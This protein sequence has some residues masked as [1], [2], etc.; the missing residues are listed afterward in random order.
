MKSDEKKENDDTYDDVDVDNVDLHTMTNNELALPKLEHPSGDASNNAGPSEV[1]GIDKKHKVIAMKSSQ[2]IVVKK[3]NSDPLHSIDE[4]EWDVDSWRLP[5]EYRMHENK[6]MCRYLS[7]YAKWAQKQS[8][9]GLNGLNNSTMESYIDKY[10]KQRKIILSNLNVGSSVDPSFSALANKTKH[11]LIEEIKKIS[12]F[13]KIP[14]FKGKSIAS[15]NGQQW[16]EIV[17]RKLGILRDRTRASDS[18]L[19]EAL[20]EK[21]SRPVFD[22]VEREM[23]EASARGVAYTLS[24]F[25][26]HIKTTYKCP[27]Y[28]YLAWSKFMHLPATMRKDMYDDVGIVKAINNFDST[29]A[30]LSHKWKVVVQDEVVKNMFLYCGTESF[31]RYL[32]TQRLEPSKLSLSQLKEAARGCNN[33]AKGKYVG[34]DEN[35][36]DYNPKLTANKQAERNDKKRNNTTNTTRTTKVQVNNLK[37]VNDQ[38]TGDKKHTQE[39]YVCFHCG[40]DSHH[41]SK[42]TLPIEKQQAKLAPDWYL[43]KYS[44]KVE[45]YRKRAASH[46][47]DTSEPNDSK[48]NPDKQLNEKHST[49]VYSTTSDDLEE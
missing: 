14:I 37:P 18:A 16:I 28:E 4:K 34:N 3:D 1:D 46:V 20:F 33:F 10:I 8:T 35:L 39:K 19:M 44:K 31:I 21:I 2:N 26:T 40:D 27:T 29:I 6:E 30:V 38:K 23:Q 25:L 45:W 9:D 49:N 5:R 48:Q 12:F 24:D 13:Q 43:K 22:I 36:V 47:A 7:Q 32:T 11:E 17:S 15:S 41:T 42:C